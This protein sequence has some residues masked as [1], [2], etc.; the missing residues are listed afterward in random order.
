MKRLLVIVGF[1]AIAVAV[2]S[3]LQDCP[4]EDGEHPVFFEDPDDCGSFYE[5][6]Y[7]KAHHIQCP[8]D[9]QLPLQHQ[10][11]NQVLKNPGNNIAVFVFACEIIVILENLLAWQSIV[12]Y[13]FRIKKYILMR[14]IMINMIVS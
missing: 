14:T 3:G 13:I 2:A 12:N 6:A 8:P 4:A 5:C 9:P 11:Q 1:L 7:G 10:H